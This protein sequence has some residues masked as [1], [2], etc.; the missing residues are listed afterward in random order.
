MSSD[1]REYSDYPFNCTRCGSGTYQEPDGDNWTLCASCSHQLAWE[2][3][4]D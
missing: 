2:T 4:K 1:D 3:A